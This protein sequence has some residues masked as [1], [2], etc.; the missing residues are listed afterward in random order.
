MEA[1]LGEQKI[2]VT[3]LPA[4][5]GSRLFRWRPPSPGLWQIEAR[6]DETGE[7]AR[8]WLS[9]DQTPKAGELPAAAPDEALLRSLAEQTSGAI[10]D[11]VP[12][13]WRRKPPPAQLLSERRQPLWHEPWF[14]A[15]LLGVY[16]LEMLLRRKWQL[17]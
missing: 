12:T 4:D 17:L 3:E 15:V 10:L 7:R 1:G 14:F 13:S 9:A 16:G 6:N 5:E 11:D 2:A 8:A